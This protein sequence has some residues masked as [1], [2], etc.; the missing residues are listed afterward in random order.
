MSLSLITYTIRLVEV[1]RTIVPSDIMQLYK[2]YPISSVTL[3]GKL[4]H[5]YLRSSYW[6]QV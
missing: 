5:A 3:L 4:N 1:M 6:F 2:I